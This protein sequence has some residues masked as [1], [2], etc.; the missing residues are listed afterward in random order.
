MMVIVSLAAAQGILV[1]RPPGCPRT[2]E[3]DP[4]E[5]MPVRKVRGRQLSTKTSRIGLA[6]PKPLLKLLNNSLRS[7]RRPGRTAG[8]RNYVARFTVLIDHARG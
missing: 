6:T 3:I 5:R 1:Q 7:N 2:A 4:H 8:S